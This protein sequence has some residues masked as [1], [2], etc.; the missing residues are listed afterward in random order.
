[1]Q[2]DTSNLS[3]IGMLNGSASYGNFDLIKKFK[4]DTGDI[5][6]SKYKSRVTGLSV[7]HLDY[8]GK[9]LTETHYISEM[10]V[11]EY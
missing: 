3:N 2:A 7:V 8:D 11:P 5:V 6:V 10:N 9:F 4:V 1:M